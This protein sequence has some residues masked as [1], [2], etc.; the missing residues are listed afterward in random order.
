MASSISLLFALALV[1]CL[2]NAIQQQQ[3]KRNADDGETVQFQQTEFCESQ[4]DSKCDFS[5]VYSESMDNRYFFRSLTSSSKYSGGIL[6]KK[7]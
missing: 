4:E 7:K 6:Q 1:F 5:E 3:Q 2:S